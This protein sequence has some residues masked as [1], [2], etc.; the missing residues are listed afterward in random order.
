MFE[1][2]HK[3]TWKMFAIGDGGKTA[4]SQYQKKLNDRWKYGFVN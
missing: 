1:N 2:I 3:K 4:I